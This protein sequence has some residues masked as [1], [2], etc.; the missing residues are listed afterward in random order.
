MGE[1]LTPLLPEKSS[2]QGEAGDDAPK[3][4]ENGLRLRF[5][6]FMLGA[7]TDVLF[8]STV[9]SVAYWKQSFG[10]SV[11]G[12][13]GMAQF[14]PS[15]IAQA[16]AL[17]FA[18]QKLDL[19]VTVAM[20][21]AAYAYMLLLC[22]AI[23]VS[24]ASGYVIPQ[25]MFLALMAM[26]G[27]CSGLA[28]SLS[29]AVAAFYGWYT[30]AKGT[31]AAHMTGVSFGV[32]VPVVVNILAAFLLHCD[33]QEEKTRLTCLLVYST[34]LVVVLVPAILMLGY[35]RTT[36]T[37]HTANEVTCDRACLLSKDTPSPVHG[38]RSML[39]TRM[40]L[41]G[42]IVTGQFGVFGVTTFLLNLTPMLVLAPSAV[43]TSQI[44]FWKVYLATL[45]LAGWSV[46]D[47]A[48]R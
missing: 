16:M 32:I 26:G 7:G 14:L 45:L 36:K 29:S 18:K 9:L 43:P 17:L 13:L 3:M 30:D 46:V 15:M 25:W 41:L 28:Q 8:Q 2:I 21:L 6:F 38:I 11:L 37:H 34:A 20:M 19:G 24:C 1:E 5:A 23:V 22:T 10:P 31:S 27:V 47:F 33:T 40:K 39:S 48:G 42:G 12:Q 35:L 44:G 4:H